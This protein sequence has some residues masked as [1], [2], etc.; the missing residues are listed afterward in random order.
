MGLTFA[1][2]PLVLAVWLL[3]LAAVALHA[4]AQPKGTLSIQTLDEVLYARWIKACGEP[5][6]AVLLRCHYLGPWLLELDVGGA[7]LW[8]WPD[9]VSAQD[10]RALRRLLHR[11]G[12]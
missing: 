9:S 5:Y 3:L 10:H 7:R 11:P 6:D 4:R 12:R 1:P 8:L 2:P